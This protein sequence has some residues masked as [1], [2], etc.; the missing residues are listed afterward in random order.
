MGHNNRGRLT[1]NAGGDWRIYTSQP[2]ANASPIGTVT[3]GDDDT[4]ALI[5]FHDSGL[6][7]QMNN[8]VVRTL[9]GRKVTA[10]LGIAGRPAELESG[11]KVNTYLDAESIATAKRLGDGNVSKGIRNALMIAAREV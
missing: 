3:R 11:K 1:V 7:A 9:D 8:G 10:A 2:P 6:Y 4:G 5:Q